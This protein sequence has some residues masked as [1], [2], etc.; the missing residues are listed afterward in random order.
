MEKKR[1]VLL[2][3]IIALIGLASFIQFQPVEVEEPVIVE[4][5]VEVV[6]EPEPEDLTPTQ[7][8]TTFTVQIL[9]NRLEP[10]VLTV[11]PG[12]T[13]VWKNKDV[14]AHKL[15]TK[16]KSYIGKRLQPGDDDFAVFNEPGE[17]QYFDA[18]HNYIQGTIIVVEDKDSFMAITGGVIASL[19]ISLS[20]FF[21]KIFG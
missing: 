20:N 17:Y 6:L 2:V 18:A 4:Q 13:V 5:P 14:R 12:S 1:W 19:T 16:D 15:L 11:S 8:T 9:F 10:K 7:P 3:V 21:K